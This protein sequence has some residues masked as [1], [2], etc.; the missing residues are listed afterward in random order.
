MR[1][2]GD[3]DAETT[4]TKLKITL[5]YFDGCPNWKTAAAHLSTLVDE[6]MDATIGYEAINTY[7]AAFARGFR[8]SPT[9]LIDGVDPFADAEA[10]VGLACR[11]YRTEDG[12][13]GTPSLPQLRHAIAAKRSP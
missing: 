5:Q 2:P 7:E 3:G 10:P 13:A 8:G 12:H 9:V 1:L 6:G 11:I 4:D